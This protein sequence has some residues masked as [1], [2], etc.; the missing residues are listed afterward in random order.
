MREIRTEFWFSLVVL[1]TMVAASV[2]RA[3]ALRA[4]DERSDLSRLPPVEAES[5]RVT[6]AFYGEPL[7]VSGVQ[8]YSARALTA[9]ILDGSTV[10]D[11]DTQLVSLAAIG[12]HDARPSRCG[13]LNCCGRN[14]CCAPRQCK[15]SCHSQF[16]AGGDYF[17]VTWPCGPCTSLIE[18]YLSQVL[19]MYE[20]ELAEQH[21]TE[22]EEFRAYEPW[23]QQA[24]VSHQM[25]DPELIPVDVESLILSALA[26]SHNLRGQ[27][28]L[29]LIREDSIIEAEAE[30]DVHSFMESRFTKTSEPVGS[31]LTLG[32]GGGDRFRDS[33]WSYSAG[34]RKQASTG[35]SIELLQRFGYEDSNSDFFDPTQQGTA[36]LALRFAQPLLYGAGRMYNTSVVVLAQIDSKI[37][38]DE[39][40]TEL[41]EHLLAVSDAY[42]SL[43]LRR[44]AL[45]QKRR[46]FERAQE[47]LKELEGRRDIDAARSQ[48]ARARAAIL[49]RKS[50]L[51]RAAA[52]VRNAEAR[53]RAL[54]NDPTLSES[55]QIELVPREFPSL[56]Y[57]P[58][59]K[60][61]ALVTALQN[62]PEVD[63]AI[64]QIRSGCLHVAVSKKELL[65]ILDLVTETYVKGLQGK[66]QVGD[67]WLDQFREG[68]PSYSVGLE[69]EMP[70]HNRAARAR[71]HRKR[72]QLRTLVSR[73]RETVENLIAEVEIAVRD[74]ET[75]HEEAQ[76]KYHAMVAALAELAA[77]TERWQLLPGDD[78]SA[79]FLLEDILDVQDR[80]LVQEF[81]FARARVAYAQSLMA[82]K[83]ATGTLLQSEQIS[84]GRACECDLK[85]LILDKTPTHRESDFHV[86]PDSAGQPATLDSPA[87]FSTAAEISPSDP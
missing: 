4:A 39:F 82:L 33:V 14:T 62:R 80:L 27:S 2:L 68:E 35:G 67:A 74:V 65:P 19:V 15:C 86:L 1:W 21:T 85:Q 38:W 6:S 81:D 66:S 7:H 63:R 34:I 44:A 13:T 5:E 32:P 61:D 69:F 17:E 26:H 12:S 48:I 43:Y 3:E 60:Q 53:I 57:V 16:L 9:T 84:I 79:S 31:A 51:S 70:L 75:A 72:L 54:I 47:I 73:Y 83:R 78:R 40:T 11:H 42:W 46:H 76:G 52:N 23:W 37:A 59:S 55:S 41:Q 8:H 29:P 77:L 28:N 36:Q 50:D 58:V 25:G 87:T 22:P 30:F 64:Q 56:D 45:L 18:P 20:N 49:A 24:V 10:N 71:H